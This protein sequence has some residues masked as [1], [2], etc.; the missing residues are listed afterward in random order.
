M[1]RPP[2]ASSPRFA[3]R[4]GISLL[5]V[6]AIWPASARAGGD[7]PDDRRVFVLGDS[8]VVGAQGALAGRLGASG[9]QVTQFASERQHTYDAPG[10]IDANAGS[11]GD[12]VVINLGANDGETPEQLAGWIDDLMERL[13]GVDRV[14]WVNLRQFADW[15]PA[16]NAELAAA[17][18]RW[19]NLQL[20]D[21]DGRSTADPSLVAA[22][23]IHLTTA[24]QDAFAELIGSTVDEE[25]GVEAPTSAS[26]T[27]TT[28]P[29]TSAPLTTAARRPRRRPGTTTA[30]G[31]ILPG[32]W[33]A[34]ASSSPG[35]D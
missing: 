25:A 8:V 9:W 34:G 18:E 23:G 4:A 30:A 24:G 28:Q 26:T 15:V 2:I 31:S 21:W 14:Y 27:S 6:A 22:D 35:S 10:I 5:F 32:S 12:T 7:E 29:P 1:R 13:R 16:S 19:T 17:E 11:I 33:W 20:I 3:R